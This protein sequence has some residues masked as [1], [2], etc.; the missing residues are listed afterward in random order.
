MT[1]TQR[2]YLKDQLLAVKARLVSE[3]EAKAAPPSRYEKY[4]QKQ[5]GRGRHTYNRPETTEE[6]RLKAQ[7]RRLDA[8]LD[9]EWERSMA[10]AEKRLGL[11]RRL[12][13]APVTSR[14]RRIEKAFTA[15]WEAVLFGKD[16]SAL[17]TVIANFEKAASR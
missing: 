10:F 5:L 8:K 11:A 13:L 7:L 17:Q 1:G 9:R 12:R 3:A 6:K 15:A 16:T 4:Y 2:K 14:V